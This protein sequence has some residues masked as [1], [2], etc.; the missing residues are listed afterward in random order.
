MDVCGPLQEESTGGARY[1]ATFIDDYSKLAHVEPLAQKSDVAEAVKKTMMRWE[2]QSGKRLKAVRT[3]RG[4]EYLNT[5]LETYFS[6]RGIVHQTTAA[7]TPEQNGVA[8]RFNRTL[9]EKVRAMLY[10]AKLDYE[11]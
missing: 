3:D 8:E 11:L 9:M 1:L 7:Y 10:D 6:S 2:T 4:T 5:E